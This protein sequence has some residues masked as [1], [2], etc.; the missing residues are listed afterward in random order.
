MRAG[1]ER[2]GLRV[3]CPSGEGIAVDVVVMG[4]GDGLRGE[5]RGA[6]EGQTEGRVG[7][8]GAA[9]RAEEVCGGPVVGSGCGGAVGGFGVEGVEGLDGASAGVGFGMGGFLLKALA[10]MLWM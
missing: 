8:A 6:D 9:V 5:R 7:P 1:G 10:R 4:A 3:F 2:A